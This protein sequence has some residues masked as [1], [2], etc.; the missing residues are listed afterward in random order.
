MKQNI[1]LSF[2][3]FI[4]TISCCNCQNNHQFYDDSIEVDSLNVPIDSLQE[5]FPREMFPDLIASWDTTVE[6]N[7]RYTVN[8]E[9]GVYDEFIVKWFS[10]QLFALNEPLLFNKEINKEVYRFTWLRSF[11]RPMAFRI[12]KSGDKYELFW[13]VTSGA[14]GYDPG[15]IVI[16]DRKSIDEEEWLEFLELVDQANFWELDL[17]IKLGG[18]DGAEWILEGL[19][20]EN[21]RVIAKW[22]PREGAFYEACNYLIELSDVK[23]RKGDKY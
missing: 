6:G 21:Y 17:G 2:L 9:E 20:E 10:K 23:I 8:P 3:L 19:S 15:E 14:G 16:D 18:S 22:T 12:E 13:K 11:H 1:S 5:Y 4:V 7:Y